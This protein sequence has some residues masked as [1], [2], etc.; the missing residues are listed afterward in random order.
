MTTM[1]RRASSS[2]IF[3]CVSFAR[4]KPGTTTT[5]GAGLSAVADTG[6]NRSAET[7]WPFCVG[8]VIPVTRTRPHEFCTQ[9]ASTLATTTTTRQP[10][11]NLRLKR[12][13]RTGRDAPFADAGPV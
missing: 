7:H 6:R 1:P 9:E 12:R 5:S 3:A 2:D 4:W 11:S 13:S 8:R 10:V